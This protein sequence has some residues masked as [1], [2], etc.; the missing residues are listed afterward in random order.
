MTRSE[1]ATAACKIIHTEAGNVYRFFCE[2]SGRLVCTTKPYREK[3]P[4]AELEKAWQT[5]GIQ[6][7]NRCQKCGC[8]VDSVMFNPDVLMC[9]DCAPIEVPPNFCPHCGARVE[10]NAGKCKICGKKLIYEGV[11]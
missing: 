7:F 6:N 4:E 3:T 1:H 10:E 9:V 8:W 11:T 2:R 5:E